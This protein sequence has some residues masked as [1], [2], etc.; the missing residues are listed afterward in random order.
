MGKSLKRSR[1]IAL[2][3][4]VMT[5]LSP[6]AMIDA[7]PATAAVQPEI[8]TRAKSTLKVNGKVFKDLNGN[9]QLDP[10]ENW[11]LPV[12]ERVDDLVS[13]MTIEEKAGMML[14]MSHYMGSS[15]SCPAPAQGGT[16]NGILCENDQWSTT[17]F[18][19]TPGSELY[20]LDPP[21]L[22]A[23]AATKGITERNLRYFIIRDNPSAKDL[24]VW[25]N[26]IQ[27]VAEG[28]RLGIPAVMISN[29]RNHASSLGFGFSEASGQFSS[30]PGELG[31]AAT[32]DPSLVKQFAQ[33]ARREWNAT[34]IRKGYMYMADIGTDPLWM[35]YNGTLG[36]SPDLTGQMIAA[37]I[38]GFQGLKL[39]SDSVALTTKHFP[40]GGTRLD[41]HDPHYSWGKPNP[42]P[43][44][45]SLFKYHIPAFQAA[46]AAGTSAIMP[47]YAKFDNSLN[48]PQLPNGQEFEE[49]GFAYNKYLITDVLRNQLG[50]KGY[51]NSDTGIITS[52]PWGVEKLT[53]PERYAKAV[54]AGVD[55]IAGDHNPADLL[56]AI[57]N[58]LITEERINKSVKLLLTESFELGLFENPYRDPEAAQKI[59]DDPVSQ[60][61]ADEAHRKSIVLLRNDNNILPLTNAKIN[62]QKL[63]V[64]VIA[65]ANAAQQTENLKK[66][67]LQYDPAISITDNLDEATRALVYVIPSGIADKPDVPLSV[68]LN[69]ET[70]VDVARIR[71][72]EEK[73]PTILTINMTS[74]WLIGEIEEKAA[75]VI[76][77]FG[78]KAE[79]LIDV[80]RGR[81]NP[82]GKLP[83][84]LPANQTAVD[85]DRSDVPGYD[86]GSE[87]VYRDKY[88]NAYG[89]GF[90]LSYTKPSFRDIA[91]LEWAKDKIELLVSKGIINGVSEELYAPEQPVTRADFLALLLRTLGL[92]S[93]S[94]SGADF[95]D[96]KPNQYYYRTVGIARGLGISQGTGNNLFNP[97]AKITWGEMTVMTE[98]ALK[99][100]N[101]GTG[102][103]QDYANKLQPTDFVD[104]AQ[105]AVL[106]YHIYTNLHK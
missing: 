59:A 53:R 13:R 57:H 34:G 51:V 96:V 4:I 55:L 30:W 31:L 15:R 66:T 60:Q 21:V 74:P 50:F 61:I 24:T 63:F 29:P 1:K 42:Y 18:W 52:M 79:A 98:R 9:G 43:S 70:G 41:G 40:G 90:G 7:N 44:E 47:Y 89:L 48:A 8:S 82:S 37:L 88:N 72:I 76:S 77:V 58:G 5:M 105:A 49:V 2:S 12:S 85:N 84:T 25:T 26:K 104:R 67:L 68:A 64:E 87:Y 20:K 11:E 80:I 32:H 19:A 100:S 16:P 36:E 97:E 83:F 28:T 91:T 99:L 93:S 71:A 23:S 95:A 56:Q 73:V 65:N 101:L 38:E 78:V 14:S 102:P 46:I 39:S 92:D 6:M 75:A 69:A 81:F 3:S 45:G 62:G 35:R 54:E 103:M 33:I 106:M 17:N 22:A 10:Y 94:E 27:E 86:E